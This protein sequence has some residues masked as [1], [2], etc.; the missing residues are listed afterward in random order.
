MK[1]AVF[2]E[3][4]VDIHLQCPNCKKYF[5]IRNYDIPQDAPSYH[6]C[7]ECSEGLVIKP[8]NIEVDQTKSSPPASCPK[9]EKKKSPKAKSPTAKL[10]PPSSAV[11]LKREAVKIIK[12]YGFKQAES[13]KAVEGVYYAGIGLEELVKKALSEFGK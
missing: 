10:E 5:R 6:N 9:E 7:L 3:Y 2:I 4:E 13:K 1:D 12:T 11:S 8:F